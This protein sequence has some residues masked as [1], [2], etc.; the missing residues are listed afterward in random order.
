MDSYR[1]LTRWQFNAPIDRVWEAIT[2]VERYPK[3]WPGIRRAYVVRSTR[4]GQVGQVVSFAVRGSLPYT[5]H[6]LSEAVESDPPRRLV[7]RA[8][9]DL[10]GRGE[11]ELTPTA[12]GTAVSYLWEVRLDKPGF[13]LLTRLPGVRRA[14][15]SNHDRVMARGGSNLARRLGGGVGG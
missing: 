9:G 12:A 8:T 7:V 1:F 2:D 10:A 3:W 15:E 5:L 6:F 4:A 14:L 13:A 11:W